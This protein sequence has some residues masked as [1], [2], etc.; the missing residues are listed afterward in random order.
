MFTASFERGINGNT[1]TTAAGEASDRAWDEIALVPKY[2]NTHVIH[3]SLAAKIPTGANICGWNQVSLEEYGRLYLY[4]TAAPS[5]F[6]YFHHFIVVL[7]AYSDGKIGFNTNFTDY[8]TITNFALNQ[9]IRIEWHVKHHTTEGIFEFKLFNEPESQIPTETIIVTNT[10]TGGSN[11]GSYSFG[12]NSGTDWGSD[13]W[14]DSIV[15]HATG[16][17]GPV[18]TT[19]LVDTF[20][21]S[22]TDGWGTSDSGHTYVTNCS[23]P[24]ALDVD[25][26]K[27]TFAPTAAGEDAGAYINI[28]NTNLT[29]LLKYRF[30]ALAVD[31][32]NR[33]EC[34]V[35]Y[36][37]NNGQGY[38]FRVQ[39]NTNGFSTLAILDSGTTVINTH[40]IAD[41]VTLE[42][43]LRWEVIGN[44]FK[45]KR[46][47]VTEAEPDWQNTFSH[48]FST[49]GSFGDGF[50]IRGIRFSSNA[51]TMYVDDLEVKPLTGFYGTPSLHTGRGST[52]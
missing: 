32:I 5:S 13:F 23:Q 11:G 47:L 7:A 51:V 2:D 26:S 3:G 8:K 52:G 18:G 24:A 16:W 44:E 27:G 19:R 31:N 28:G 6:C 10:N 39:D 45:A 48:T 20:S 40:T 37:I 49:G 34:F 35:K 22:V 42:H 33:I 14:L 29:G 46:W 9:W 36:N 43:Y 41:D 38:Y 30:S 15:A 17:P 21:R 50:N 1:I 12:N 25:G 4:A